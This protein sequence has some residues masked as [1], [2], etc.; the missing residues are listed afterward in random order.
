MDNNTIND[1]LKAGLNEI[2][3]ELAMHDA[4]R[5]LSK[6]FAQRIRWGNVIDAE[7]M[8]EYGREVPYLFVLKPDTKDAQGNVIVTIEVTDVY[9]LEQVYQHNTK[10][11]GGSFTRYTPAAYSAPLDGEHEKDEIIQTLL[12]TAIARIKGILFVEEMDDEE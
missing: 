8:D 11:L 2:D 4:I 3:D 7:I 1:I 9:K 12:A 10:I 5:E 6:D